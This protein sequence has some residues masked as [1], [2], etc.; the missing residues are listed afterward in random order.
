MKPTFIRRAPQTLIKASQPFERLSVD[1]KEPLSSSSRNRYLLTVVDEY[2]R[3]PFAFPCADV[4]APTVIKHLTNLFSVFGNP[5][6]VNSDRGT[7]FMSEEQKGFLHSRSIAT[8]RTTAFNPQGQVE[9]YNSIIWQTVSLAIRARNLSIVN[10]KKVLDM[11]LHYI[12]SLLSTSTNGTPHERLF[13]FQRKSAT[14]DSIP[15]WLTRS[16]SALLK[17][18]LRRS[19]YEPLVETVDILEVNPN[20]AHVRFNNGRETA[21]SL[22]HIAPLGNGMN[23]LD[24]KPDPM[25]GDPQELDVPNPSNAPPLLQSTTENSAAENSLPAISLPPLLDDSQRT[26]S[27]DADSLNIRRS[28]RTCR[29]PP[30]LTEN[31]Q[32]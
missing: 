21:V 22:R 17:R 2:S 32:L 10:W 24:T 13:N 11:A 3:F 12:R 1:F 7:A 4:A 8:S 5:S 27:K 9:R 29:R 16:K 26:L 15:T 19:K 30:Y 31:Y 6:L 20:Y 25:P 28:S 23:S 18:H 14:R